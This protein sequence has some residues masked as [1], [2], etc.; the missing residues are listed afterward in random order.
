MCIETGPVLVILGF[1]GAIGQVC[2]SAFRFV[3]PR[4]RDASR[5]DVL[6]T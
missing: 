4:A 3:H 1:T 5:Q 6:S 2:A